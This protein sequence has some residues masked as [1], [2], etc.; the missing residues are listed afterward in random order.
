MKTHTHVFEFYKRVRSHANSAE[1]LVFP[2]QPS[3]FP[4]FSLLSP[5]AKVLIITSL[6]KWKCEPRKQDAAKISLALSLSLARSLA[7]SLIDSPGEQL[8]VGTAA[9]SGSSVPL[10][11]TVSLAEEISPTRR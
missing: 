10:T 4:F 2:I 7:R 5:Q 11:Q 3:S 6:A 8:V 9:W 1:R